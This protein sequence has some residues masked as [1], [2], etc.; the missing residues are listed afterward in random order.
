MCN[1]CDFIRK[2]YVKTDCEQSRTEFVSAVDTGT[3][4]F[5]VLLLASNSR[6]CGNSVSPPRSETKQLKINQLG[7]V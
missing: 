1:A 6:A 3:P 4:V 5:L 2:A 7:V